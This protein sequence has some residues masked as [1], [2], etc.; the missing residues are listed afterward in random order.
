M[1]RLNFLF[2][3]NFL[4]HFN[5]VWKTYLFQVI[6]ERREEYRTTPKDEENNAP[7]E[8]DFQIFKRF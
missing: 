4:S 6:K 1:F 7:R 8:Y 5:E 3:P 2:A